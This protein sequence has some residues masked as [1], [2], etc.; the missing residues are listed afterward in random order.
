MK[1]NCD[2]IY[3]VNPEDDINPI[4]IR[5]AMLKCFFE[6]DKDVL[7][8]LFLKSDFQ[9]N[10]DIEIGKKHVEIV[11]K[12]MFNDVNGDFNNPTKKSLINVVNK[13]KEYAGLFRDKET[14]EK[15]ANEIMTLINMLD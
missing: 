14:I 7:K 2:L 1:E 4:I 3:G 13:C 8:K 6:A 5:D 10:E 11:I 9:S 15:H 12:K